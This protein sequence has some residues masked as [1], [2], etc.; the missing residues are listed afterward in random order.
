[1]EK[2]NPKLLIAKMNG[3]LNDVE[4][5]Q[6][7]NFPS[8]KFYPGNAKDKEPKNFHTRRN[9]TSLIRFIKKNAIHKIIEEEELQKNTEL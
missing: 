4:E 9:I 5:Y 7:Q 1:M 2:N 3:I 6:I 8:T